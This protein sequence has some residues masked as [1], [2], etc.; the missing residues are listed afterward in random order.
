[1]SL[2]EKNLF[3]ARLQHRAI[4]LTAELFEKGGVDK[5]RGGAELMVS[6]YGTYQNK[7][8][9][10]SISVRDL[11]ARS[12]WLEARERK[13]KTGEACFLVLAKFLDGP[14]SG[15]DAT[16]EDLRK[17]YDEHIDARVKLYQIYERMTKS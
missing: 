17:A 8:L 14:S 2:E 9:M 10:V 12:E 5:V 4:E 11:E 3:L 13:D 16:F 15:Y 1:M 6:D 7:E